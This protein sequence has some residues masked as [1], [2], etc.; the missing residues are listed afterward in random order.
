[1]NVPLFNY[2]IL[3]FIAL[4]TL[5]LF[6]FFLRK[7]LEAYN[8]YKESIIEDT[9][10]FYQVQRKLIPKLQCTEKDYLSYSSQME[11]IE[12]S[13]RKKFFKP[14]PTFPGNGQWEKEMAYYEWH[15]ELNQ[16][17]HSFYAD[18]LKSSIPPEKIISLLHDLAKS[19]DKHT[20]EGLDTVLEEIRESALSN[21]SPELEQDI[22]LQSTIN[23]II[24]HYSEASNH[25]KF[26]FIYKVIHQAGG[27]YTSASELPIFQNIDKDELVQK[28]GVIE[29]IEI[30]HIKADIG[31]VFL[32]AFSIEPGVHFPLMSL[33]KS[34]IRNTRDS[35]KGDK[36]FED[37]IQNILEDSF[38]VIIGKSAGGAIS[39][40]T[41]NPVSGYLSSLII[42]TGLK[43]LIR[44]EKMKIVK[45]EIENYK[46]VVTTQKKKVNK[47]FRQSADTINE[48][49]NEKNLIYNQL[50]TQKPNDR[51]EEYNTLTTTS[52]GKFNEDLNK[53]ITIFERKKKRIYYYIP[54]LRKSVNIQL[55]SLYAMQK[56]AKLNIESKGLSYAT[57]F[58]FPIIRNGVLDQY[59]QHASDQFTQLNIELSKDIKKWNER[60]QKHRLEA[61]E[62][63]ANRYKIENGKISEEKSN[64]QKQIEAAKVK[65]E[66]LCKEKN[67]KL[68]TKNQR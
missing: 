29:H 13:A 38:V 53:Y 58:S 36:N 10:D 22:D 40:F 20:T 25:E 61:S 1:M 44:S 35:I 28:I 32:E 21:P 65:L 3:L 4:A 24:D 64:A 55:S 37:A 7:F 43:L 30:T 9:P 66:Q 5:A 52:F 19:I 63:K 46:E 54:S 16:N 47:Q 50:I 68:N 39:F 8:Q 31:E 56:Q 60:L 67:I 33:A 27:D 11:Q 15:F 48:W 49:I 12:A 62:E 23:H 17:K 45:L 59:L 14:I 34:I 6:Y 18:A 26:K 57:I 51:K 41:G 42:I 2:G